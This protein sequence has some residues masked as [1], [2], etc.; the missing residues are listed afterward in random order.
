VSLILTRVGFS[1]SRSKATPAI[2][3]RAVLLS[4]AR[5]TSPSSSA[6]FVVFD[7]FIVCIVTAGSLIFVIKVSHVVLLAVISVFTVIP[8]YYPNSKG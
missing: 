2:D 1:L 6:P 8:D 5:T 3:F 4:V 7:F